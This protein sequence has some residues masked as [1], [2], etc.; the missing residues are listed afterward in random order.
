MFA[1]WGTAEGFVV[2]SLHGGP[3]SRF[4]RFFDERVY[5][6]M[7]ARVI[8][9]DRPG[10]GGS[11]RRRGRSVAD[12]V[13]DVAAI[14]DRLDVDRFAVTGG[15]VGGPHCLAVAAGLPERV[16]GAI[17]TAGPA[18]F[19][20]PGLDWFEGMDPLNVREIDWALAGEDVLAPEL[21]VRRPGCSN[22]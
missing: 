9:Y 4:G 7:G 11:D 18:P 1:E 22:K 10:Y 15:S 14:A 17:C 19:D 6:E 16:I 5:A 3:G 21:D 20:A 2:F 13:D 8:T 12:C